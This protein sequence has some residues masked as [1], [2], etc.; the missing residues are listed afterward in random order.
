MKKLTILGALALTASASALTDSSTGDIKAFTIEGVIGYSFAMLPDING[1]LTL[2]VLRAID[3]GY[4]VIGRSEVLGGK[5]IFTDAELA[6]GRVTQLHGADFVLL[7]DNKADLVLSLTETLALIAT[8]G[9]SESRSMD[10]TLGD[11]TTFVPTKSIKGATT[12][13][14]LVFGNETYGVYVNADTTAVVTI[15]VSDPSCIVAT[16]TIGMIRTSDLATSIDKVELAEDGRI[17]A[18]TVP[19]FTSTRRPPAGQTTIA[20]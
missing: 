9:L 14:V 19:T 7:S 13:T 15:D 2:T 12:L 17:G 1:H 20:A 4:K 18:S 6:N 16:S 8:A 5:I 10:M 3:D 11:V